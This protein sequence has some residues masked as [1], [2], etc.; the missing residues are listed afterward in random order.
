MRVD[1]PDDGTPEGRRLEPN[2]RHSPALLP[3]SYSSLP[4][5]NYPQRKPFGPPADHSTRCLPGPPRGDPSSGG[6]S[7]NGPPRPPYRG[8]PIPPRRGP[9]DDP[10]PPPG[11]GYASEDTPLPRGGPA[12]R[13]PPDFT[14]DVLRRFKWENVP[15]WHGEGMKALNWLREVERI[16]EMSPALAQLL[17]KIVP[18]RLKG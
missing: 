10:P 1:M 9:P 6:G 14:A 18:Q 2:P 17:G 3:S 4:N 12:P 13:A 11:A 7:P 5:S 16:A 8:P 15:E